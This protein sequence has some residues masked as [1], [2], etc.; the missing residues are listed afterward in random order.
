MVNIEKDVCCF[1][2]ADD[3]YG[4]FGNIVKNYK[5]VLENTFVLKLIRESS[6]MQIVSNA[7]ITS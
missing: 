3:I 1:E 4:N 7:T 2:I 6:Q 5:Q